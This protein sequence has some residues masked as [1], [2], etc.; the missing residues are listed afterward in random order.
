MNAST[1]KVKH[2]VSDI[3]RR[4]RRRAL[5]QGAALT[6]LVLLFFATALLLLY[7]TV[8]ASPLALVLVGGVAV[9]VVLG[10][11]V[12][13]LVR[14]AFRKIPDQ[15]IALFVEEKIPDLE[16]RL[17]SAVEVDD[18][19]RLRKEH[20]ALIDRLID[21]AARRALAIPMT[22][23]VDRKRERVL[24][25]SAGA[26]LFVFL[27]FGYTS[28]DKITLSQIDLAALARPAQP[29]MT[30]SPGNLEIE[31][32]A[33]QEIIATL[34]DDTDREVVLVYKEG[35][36]DWQKAPMR[37]G[38]GETAFF[39]ELPNIQAAVQYYVEVQDTRSDPYVLSLY[40][41]PDVAQID[42][43]YRFPAYT[44]LPPRTE[45]DAGDIRGLKGST[46]TLNVH[47]TGAV[48]TA[49]LIL[50][51]DQRLPLQ[52]RG[53]GLYQATLQLEDPHIY[54]VR[55]QDQQ[56]KENKFPDEYQIV[57][58][59]DEQP[60]ITITDPQRDVR[61]NALEEVLV[62]ASAQDDFGV[63]D[64]RL[65]FSVNGD[66]E[67]TIRLMN[68]DAERSP[69]ASG[70]HLFF[71]EDY[72]LEPGDVISYYVEAEDFFHAEAP[73]AT[74][75]YF[76]EVIPFDQQYRQANNMSGMQG[77]QPSGLVLS[78]Q[79]IIAATWKLHRERTEMDAA[80]VE[81]ARQAL[82]Q[83][84]ANLKRN[85][86]ERINATAFSLELRTSEEN[87]KIV[88]YLRQAV[89]EMGK[90]VLDLTADRLKPAL[91]P[92]RKALNHL[93]KADALNKEQQVAMQRG[94]QGG[95]QSATEE[96][97]TELMDLELDISKDKYEMQ[98]QR[99]QQ[100]QQQQMDEALQKIRELARKQQNLAN[101]NRLDELQG[102][103]K[104]RFIDQLKRDQEELRRQ[105][106]R[107]AG[108][109]Q[110]ASRERGEQGR[111]MQQ[112]LERVAENM[113]EAEQALRRGD[114]QKAQARQQ[115]AL[116][117]LQ[118]LQRDL[119]LAANDNAR[120][121]VEDL[122]QQFDQFR[123]QERQLADD[124]QR[125]E[126]DARDGQPD[127]KTLDGL[128]QKRQQMIDNLEQLD[129]QAQAVQER[130]RQDDPE[131][132]TA[133]RNM[134]QQA[135]RERLEANM[136]NSEDAIEQ[137]WLDYANRLEDEI[138]TALEKMETQRRAFDRSLPVGEE[139]QL[140]RALEDVRDLMRQLEDVQRR[141]AGQQGRPATQPDD[142]RQGQ[143]Q[144]QGQGQPS[145]RAARA[146]AARTQRQMEQARENLERLQ[147][148]L[149]GNATAQRQLRQVESFLTR[150]DHTGV[151][152]QGDA[153]KAFFNERVFDPL[154]QLEMEI[155]RQLDLIEMEKKLYGGRSPDV[156]AEYRDLVEQYYEALAK[157]KKR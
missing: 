113:R 60:Y 80:E 56:N 27:L 89:D 106:E 147:R 111:E 153:A 69:E 10:V 133:I 90:A 3:R 1:Y 137:G 157:T 41:F 99:A 76:I 131:L 110:Q 23:V 150:A 66:D 91:T 154:A 96:R 2:L 47:T 94:G 78:Q 50:D 108:G 72:S 15:Q 105:A 17:N 87:R 36:D 12:Q 155:A 21:D 34:R 71:L 101:Q 136:L 134:L 37:K 9:L 29:F 103:D 83:A 82:V 28:L 68:A 6:L 146:E 122:A 128:R 102:E 18:A 142:P 84:Q 7:T 88:E 30:V 26:F 130:I 44:G 135:R 112:R 67:Q 58:I 24:A 42:V 149:A 61:T 52:A 53:D 100:Q 22:T 55:L 95:G 92:E 79:Q 127:Q 75:M 104:K 119:Q 62:A 97:M 120:G 123:D 16:D 65:R 109:M 129:A 11:A 39:A 4:W 49:E 85:I 132:A 51:D 35:E 126:A 93:L 33:S 114:V 40:E 115:Q 48:A 59:E 145:D 25:Y 57:P 73:E 31:R 81:E 116:N 144:G 139:E 46:V 156:P 117:E 5:G 20:G 63:K 77:Q 74:D 148:D 107:M 38:L 152:L 121:A 43:T 118:Q 140:A 54:S 45:E 141:A 138:Q 125:A 19:A 86:E 98:Q 143:E 151:L 64:L 70:E 124:L 8:E 13:F 14:P 32:G